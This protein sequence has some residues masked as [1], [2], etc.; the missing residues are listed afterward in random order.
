MYTTTVAGTYNWTTGSAVLE[1]G[2]VLIA[3]SDGVL[4]NVAD[5]TIVQNNLGQA[6]ET[7][8]GYVRIATQ[9]E[10]DLTTSTLDTAAITPMKLNAWVIDGGTF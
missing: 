7:T 6:D 5:W 2:D 3:E 4:N 10:T 8:D 1:I 9:V